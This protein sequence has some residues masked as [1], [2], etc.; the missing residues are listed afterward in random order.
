[1]NFAF[2]NNEL[3]EVFK[4]YSSLVEKCETVGTGTLLPVVSTAAA[5]N[6][7]NSAAVFSPLDLR[8][9]VG[10][11]H[12]NSKGGGGSVMVMEDDRDGVDSDCSADINVESDDDIHLHISPTQQSPAG[13]QFCKGDI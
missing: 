2:C 5:N 6:L 8:G 13:R 10:S 12:N 11:G 9:V 7:V 3:I 4:M 1:M